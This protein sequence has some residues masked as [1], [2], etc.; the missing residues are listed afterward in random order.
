MFYIIC[1]I[2]I[3]L[4][5]CIRIFIDRKSD[6]VTC[7]VGKTAIV[8]GGNSGLGYET[9]LLLASRGCRVIIADRENGVKSR[10]EI[11]RATSNPNILYKYLDLSSA[12]EVRQF[13]ADICKSEEKIDILINNAGISVSPKFLTEDGINAV[14]QINYFGAF[15]LTHL[16]MNLLKASGSARI[17]FLGSVSIFFHNLRLDNL[18]LKNYDEKSELIKVYANSKL[19]NVLAA[20]EFGRR[21][22]KFGI[23]ANSVD[24]GAVRTR[25]FRLAE[26]IHYSLF[27]KILKNLVLFPLGQEPFSGAQTIFHVASSKELENKTGGHYSFLSSWFK[28][29]VLRDQEFC[30]EIWKKTEQLVGLQPEEKLIQ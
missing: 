17:V 19:C 26:E 6:S 9:S 28:P 15:L 27:F 16:L 1:L 14:M 5:L 18:N 21:I 3:V 30:D 29:S 7:L 24:P 11:I 13:A 2:F 25:I 10:D 12:K 8:T 4:Y 22:Q 20:Q 23:T